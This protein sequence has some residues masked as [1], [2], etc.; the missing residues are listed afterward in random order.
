MKNIYFISLIFLYILNA[1]SFPIGRQIA[2]C[3]RNINITG[4]KYI[5]DIDG[6]I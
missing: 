2:K 6:T 1:N 5:V 4:K 3:E